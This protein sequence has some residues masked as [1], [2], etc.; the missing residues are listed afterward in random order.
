MYFLINVMRVRQ[1]YSFADNKLP[2]ENWEE[3]GES[4]VAMNHT[5]RYKGFD[6]DWKSADEILKMKE[7]VNSRGV[8]L[9]LNVGPDYFGRIPAP[10][11]QILKEIG[12]RIKK[13]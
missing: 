7:A 13:S 5:W 1:A 9:L 12:N 8:N 11:V 2:E 3:L 10:S 4:F 6:N